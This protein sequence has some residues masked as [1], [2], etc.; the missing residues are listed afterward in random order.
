MFHEVETIHMEYTMDRRDTIRETQG[1]QT[2]NFL[3][4]SSLDDR[5][6]KLQ[7]N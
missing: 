7:N 2:Y 6:N 1:Q 5:P 4:Q 3:R